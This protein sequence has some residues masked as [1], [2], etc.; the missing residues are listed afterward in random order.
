[1]NKHN[2]STAHDIALLAE[3]CMQIEI[4]RKV[5]CSQQH[6]TF[7]IKS[8]KEKLTRYRWENTNKLLGNIEGFIGCKTGITNAAGPC[9][10]GC[11]EKGEDKLIIVVLCSKSME[12]RWIEVPKMAEWA[13]KRNDML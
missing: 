10:A 1:M 12:Q 4:F 9:Y 3:K 13:I 2:Y 8:K 5:V 6:E 7:A 11:F